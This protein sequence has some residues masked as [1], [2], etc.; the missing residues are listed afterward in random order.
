MTKC[1]K[2]NVLGNEEVQILHLQFLGATIILYQVS[3]IL[4]CVCV[5]VFLMAVARGT[6][7]IIPH[8]PI[9]KSRGLQVIT[10]DQCRV[11]TH[12][13]CGFAALIRPAQPAGKVVCVSE[14]RD[15]RDTQTETGRKTNKWTWQAEKR[16]LHANCSWAERITAVT[17]TLRVY[18]KCNIM[19]LKM[20]GIVKGETSC[21]EAFRP[22]TSHREPGGAGCH[23]HVS[24]LCELLHQA[25]PCLL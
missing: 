24:G 13:Q 16:Q 7:P 1:S 10:I 3:S 18:L 14:R 8:S 17:V 21:S 6:V 9:T 4:M 25:E 12:T 5:C 23:P 22:V 2:N 15:N 11:H 20:A 19:S